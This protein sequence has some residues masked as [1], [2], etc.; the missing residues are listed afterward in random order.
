LT[1]KV[2]KDVKLTA[3]RVKA[4]CLNQRL[5]PEKP[6]KPYDTPKTICPKCGGKIDAAAA[7]SGDR[8]PRE[9]DLSVCAYC[10]TL[11]LYCAD[12]TLRLPTPAEHQRLAL[13]PDVMRTQ[14]V[15]AALRP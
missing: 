15:L 14:I 9:G 13:N 11:S 7:V 3:Q 8:P 6:M 1:A 5:E 4:P 2:H 12:L 10:T